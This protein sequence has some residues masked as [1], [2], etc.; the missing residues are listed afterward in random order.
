MPCED[1]STSQITVGDCTLKSE[2]I[3]SSPANV[4][5]LVILQ[6]LIDAINDGHLFCVGS[7]SSGCKEMTVLSLD[8]EVDFASLL[9]ESLSSMDVA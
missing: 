8:L 6:D 7:E 9:C 5:N 3:D 2:L 4:T 1:N